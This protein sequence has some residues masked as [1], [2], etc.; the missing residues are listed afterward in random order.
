MKRGNKIKRQI[1]ENTWKMQKSNEKKTRNLRLDWKKEIA[2]AIQCMAMKTNL[3]EKRAKS[4]TQALIG[5]QFDP[6]IC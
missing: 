4:Y 5:F 3:R 1:E 2:F 6:C